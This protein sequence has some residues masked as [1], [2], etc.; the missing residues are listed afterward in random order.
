MAKITITTQSNA[1]QVI[2]DTD[3]KQSAVKP[4]AGITVTSVKSGAQIVH[5]QVS[6]SS[7]VFD[8]PA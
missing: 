6:N 3:G 7:V 4:S 2:L 1:Q 8:S 5:G